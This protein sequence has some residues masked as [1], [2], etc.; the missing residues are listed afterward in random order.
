MPPLNKISRFILCYRQC[1]GEKY[2]SFS[3]IRGITFQYL[4]KKNRIYQIILIEVDY[5]L[6]IS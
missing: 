2:Y 3:I 6:E 4:L 5:L 1:N